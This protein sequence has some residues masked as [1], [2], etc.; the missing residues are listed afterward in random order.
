MSKFPTTIY[1][2]RRIAMLES[3]TRE[4]RDFIACINQQINKGRKLRLYSLPINPD[5]SRPA[6]YKCEDRPDWNIE[7]ITEAEKW[8]D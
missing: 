2:I 6:K 4:Q 8:S 1:N 7:L 3:I 5:E